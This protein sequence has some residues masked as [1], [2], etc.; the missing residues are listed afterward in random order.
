MFH[1]GTNFGFYNGCS[2]HNGIDP[3]TTTYDYDAPLTEWGEFADKYYKF[4]DVISNYT[5][6]PNIKLTT[7]IKFKKLWSN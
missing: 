7:D 6:I 4:R 1:G 5:E 3:Q 2:Y